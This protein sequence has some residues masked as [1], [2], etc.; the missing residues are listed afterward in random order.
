MSFTQNDFYFIDI[1]HHLSILVFMKNMS[2]AHCIGKIDLVNFFILDALGKRNFPN[3][4]KTFIARRARQYLHADIVNAKRQLIG[5]AE[6]GFQT[7]YM[8][9]ARSFVRTAIL[10][11]AHARGANSLHAA[12]NV[13]W[14]YAPARVLCL[15][16]INIRH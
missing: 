15:V 8:C 12:A 13:H 6:L 14:S 16:E 5:T 4:K 10:F 11:T 2:R 7:K 1:D 3:R 9:T